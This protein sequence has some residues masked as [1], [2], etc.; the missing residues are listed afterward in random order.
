MFILHLVFDVLF[1]KCL[2]LTFPSVSSSSSLFLVILHLL[3]SF[4]MH[5]LDPRLLLPWVSLS[6][7]LLL[8]LPPSHPPPA[9]SLFSSSSSTFIFNP[10]FSL[11]FSSFFSPSSFPFSPKTSSCFSSY[12]HI[13]LLLISSSWFA[14]LIMF[15]HLNFQIHVT[16]SSV[17]LLYSIFSSSFSP[18]TSSFFLSTILL[19]I[20]YICAGPSS[21]LRDQ[22]RA[23]EITPILRE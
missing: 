12:F 20:L 6:F 14:L 15:V 2:F 8:L 19:F 5:P 16:P 10:S 21:P 11:F 22:E 17:S 7:C 23:E 13:I 1:G 9:S 4:L 18:S 3:L